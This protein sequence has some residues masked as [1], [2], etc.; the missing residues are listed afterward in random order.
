MSAPFFLGKIIDVIYTNPAADYSCSLTRLCLALSGVFFCGAAANAIRV[1]LM[2]TSGETPS[3]WVW[4]ILE[5]AQGVFPGSPGLG[6]LI[7]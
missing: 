2:Q 4:G 5:N 3:A 6:L 7:L 1:Y